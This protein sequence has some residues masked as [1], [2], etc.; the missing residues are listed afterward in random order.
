MKGEFTCT[1]DVER[2]SEDMQ[3]M[4]RECTGDTQ[5]IRSRDCM[6][7]RRYT[8]KCGRLSVKKRKAYGATCLVIFCNDDSFGSRSLTDSLYHLRAPRVVM[9]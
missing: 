1:A 7:K 9:L 5:E 2:E 6:R 4:R 3:K 8:E